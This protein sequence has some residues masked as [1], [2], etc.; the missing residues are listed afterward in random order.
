M[1]QTETPALYTTAINN[2]DIGSKVENEYSIRRF[3]HINQARFSVD[4]PAHVL[5]THG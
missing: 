5:I 4:R 3:T 1:V 2:V